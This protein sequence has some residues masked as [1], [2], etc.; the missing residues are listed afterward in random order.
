VEFQKIPKLTNYYFRLKGGGRGNPLIKTPE[1][2]V[3][4]CA[5]NG[6]WGGTI[7]RWMPVS[8]GFRLGRTLFASLRKKR[9]GKTEENGVS[10]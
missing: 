2:P 10:I 1:H 5:Q 9:S 7:K 4:P 8:K 6:G 3:L